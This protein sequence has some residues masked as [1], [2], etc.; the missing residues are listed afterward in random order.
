[1][2]SATGTTHAG[3]RGASRGGRGLMVPSTSST[4]STRGLIIVN[5]E[6]RVGGRGS[7][8]NARLPAV[9]LCV[10]LDMV[11]IVVPRLRDNF[12][13]RRTVAERLGDESRSQRVRSEARGVDANGG[14]ASLHHVIDG[15]P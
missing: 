3:S 12:A 6:S 1:M 11:V 8:F 10:S 9:I 14:D 7:S 13:V 5:L 4:T 15:L 2:G